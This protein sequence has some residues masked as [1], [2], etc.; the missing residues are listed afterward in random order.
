M[1]NNLIEYIKSSRA[2]LKHASWP[3]R[4]ETIRFTIIVIGVSFFVAAFLGGLDLLF[5]YGL[6]RFV[7]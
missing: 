5:T 1:L 7:L 4:K 6:E 3:T 2:E